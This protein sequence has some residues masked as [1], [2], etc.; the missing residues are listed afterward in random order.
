MSTLS[1]PADGP[2]GTWIRSTLNAKFGLPTSDWSDSDDAESDDNSEIAIQLHPIFRRTILADQWQ[3]VRLGKDV[4]FTIPEIGSIP[5]TTMEELFKTRKAVM[6]VENQVAFRW[7]KIFITKTMTGLAPPV[8]QP[9]DVIFGIL[10]CDVPYLLRKCD[11]GYNFL[12]EW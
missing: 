7:R 4:T 8:A 12:G 10:G 6:N 5:P 9:G 2:A 11:R 3:G 1:F